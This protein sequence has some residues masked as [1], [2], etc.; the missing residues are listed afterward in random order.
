MGEGDHRCVVCPPE[1]PTQVHQD[2]HVEDGAVVVAEHV[3]VVEPVDEVAVL[4][5]QKKGIKNSCLPSTVPKC[6]V[7]V[8][9]QWLLDA[10]AN[11]PRLDDHHVDVGS[12]VGRRRSS[13]ISRKAFN[14]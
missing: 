2:H 8:E 6:V 3:A 11:A 5:E 14:C 4:R 13:W 10:I 12:R 9:T 1:R 7:V